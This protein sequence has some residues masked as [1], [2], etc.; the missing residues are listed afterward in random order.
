MPYDRQKAVQYAHK[1]AY[2]RNKRYLQFD[3]LGGDCTNFISQCLYAGGMPMNYKKIFGW[4][5]I[6]ANN[7]APAWTGAQYLNNFLITN[8]GVGPSAKRVDITGIRP[9]DVI[10]LSFTQGLLSH[11][12]F[13]VETGAVPDIHNVLIATH[14]D[15]SD[16]RPLDT[17]HPLEMQF[18]SVYM[19]E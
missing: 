10:Q 18:M 9:G 1:W 12:L 11:S 3:G 15:D 19:K 17:Y 5:Y 4:Y 2:G 16:Y 14:T 6:S 7:R 8:K 13:V